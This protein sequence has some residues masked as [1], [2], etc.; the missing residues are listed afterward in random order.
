MLLEAVS[1]LGVS[2]WGS[3][4]DSQS[5]SAS[6]C[7]ALRT[8][9]GLFGKDLVRCYQTSKLFLNIQR[10]HMTTW[11]PSGQR[12][13]TGLGWRHFDVP[14]CGSLLLSELVLEL[15]EAFAVGEEI[16]TF[17][18]PKELRDKARFLLVH[19]TKRRS[20]IQRARER[21][22]REHTYLHRIQHW[23]KWFNRLPRK[24]PTCASS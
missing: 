14:A 7:R 24:G 21:V 20:M 11:T 15:P 9:R 4:W 16:E 2:I 18:S 22:L 8:R 10:E 13:G 6:L 3:N 19:E 12:I 17:S 23:I 5:S 1:D